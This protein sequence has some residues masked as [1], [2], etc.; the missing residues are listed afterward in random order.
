MFE[1]QLYLSCLKFSDHIFYVFVFNGE[2][3]K[4]LTEQITQC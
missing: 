3:Q 1:K 4:T 2:E